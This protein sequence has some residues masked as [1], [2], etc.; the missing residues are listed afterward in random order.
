M[1]RASD[2]G[3]ELC[4]VEPVH[5]LGRHGGGHLHGA[6]VAEGT[7]GTNDDQRIDVN[8]ELPLCRELQSIVD[9]GCSNPAIDPVFGAV[10]SRYWSSSTGGPV[11]GWNVFLLDGSVGTFHKDLARYV[12]VVRSGP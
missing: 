12:G 6:D 5:R 3:S 9:Y 11:C 1:R 4:A 2:V 7:A 10:S 8:D